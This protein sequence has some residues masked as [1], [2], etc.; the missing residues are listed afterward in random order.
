ITRQLDPTR[1]F[2]LILEKALEMTSAP[3]G[4]L[5]RYDAH[6]ERL[7][8]AAERGVRPERKN[9]AHSIDEGIVGLAGRNRQLV[10]VGDVTQPPW[11][12]IH[13]TFIPNVR[14]E[15]AVPLL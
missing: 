8:M 6:T 13:L 10:N 14:S 3:T 5:M 15:L 2:D 1:V 4:T 7:W 11:D 12:T 9:Q